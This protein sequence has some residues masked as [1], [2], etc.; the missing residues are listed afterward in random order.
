MSLPKPGKHKALD[1]CRGGASG[2][3]GWEWSRAEPGGRGKRLWSREQWGSRAGERD[4]GQGLSQHCCACGGV[5]ELCG[6]GEG[7][8][9]SWGYHQPALRCILW[10]SWSVFGRE[11]QEGRFVPVALGWGMC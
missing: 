2:A 10:H 11:G 3:E 7:S 4:H 5:G 1:K 8:W 9:A 6:L